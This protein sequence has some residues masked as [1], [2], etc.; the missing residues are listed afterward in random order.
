MEFFRIMLGA[1]IGDIIGSRWEFNPTN[2]YNFEL[3]SDKNNFTDDTICTIA[4]A[5]ALLHNSEDYGKYIH[6]WCRKY[7]N[8]MGGYGVSFAKWVKSD[9]PQPYGSYGNGSAMRVSPIGWWFGFPQDLYEQSAKVASCTHNHED[10]ITGAQT[11]AIAVADARVFRK[12]LGRYPTRGDIDV[13]TIPHAIMQYY[14]YPHLFKLNIDDYRNKF[15]ETCQGT[16]PPALW[17]VLNSISFEDA[18]RQ[19][20]SLGADADT[21][22]VIVGSIAEPIWGIPEGIKQKALSYL[23]EDMK[24]VVKEFHS[25][26]RKL[27]EL[28]KDNQYYKFGEFTSDRDKHEDVYQ[29]EKM[30]SHDLAGDN[31][32]ERKTIEEMA[33]RFP[34]E[35]WQEIS[36]KYD[37]PLSLIG[38]LSKAVLNKRHKTLKAVANFIEYHYSMRKKQAKIKLGERL[39][40]QQFMAIMFWKLCL[41]NPNKFFEGKNPLPDKSKL[42]TSSDCQIEPL[43]TDTNDV[44]DVPLNFILSNEDLEIIR[45]GHIPEVQEDHWFMYCDEQYIRY[46]RSWTGACA[47]E[48][49]YEISENGYR[50]DNLKMNRALSEFGVNGDDAGVALFQYLLIAETGGNSEL[51]WQHYL[52]E[53]DRLNKKYT[54]K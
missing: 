19:A 15:D 48:A 41:G 22:G 54:K 29:I 17:I 1:I 25:R 35:Q 23:P 7:P 51:A 40:K 31:T 28:S 27:R 11:V 36:D 43:P 49:H 18:I 34:L 8:P 33:E 52:D 44:S 10:G 45:R 16:V 39:K 47:F 50:I 12:D 42:A 21:L 20:V 9:N 14:G 5:D 26:V 24:A 6:K 53:W 13:Y 37:L 30:W 3:F 32:I 46:Y 4:V 2:D 38:Y